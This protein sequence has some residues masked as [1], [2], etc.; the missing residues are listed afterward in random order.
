MSVCLIKLS[1]GT[2]IVGDVKECIQ[3]F[4][5]IEKPLMLHYR[6]YL[7]GVPS[8]SFSRYMLF[9][10]SNTITIQNSQMIAKTEARKAFADYYQD[11]VD[12]YY[13]DLVSSIDEELKSLLTSTEKE[14]A[15]KK[16]LEMMPTD[17]AQM[18]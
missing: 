6:F 3:Q 1:D 4:T 2:E 13:G 10:S 18:N 17:K 11:C 12:D 15:L 5:I 9:A 7:G 14:Q 16:L 8:V